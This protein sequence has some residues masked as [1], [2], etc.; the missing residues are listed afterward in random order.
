MWPPRYSNFRVFLSFKILSLYLLNFKPQSFF[1]L[2]LI[3]GCRFVFFYIWSTYLH[4]LFRCICM[5]IYCLYKLPLF[6]KVWI[7]FPFLV[8]SINFFLRWAFIFLFCF[9]I[10]ILN[11]VKYKFSFTVWHMLGPIKKIKSW[12][13][14]TLK[15]NL[16]KRNWFF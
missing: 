6:K 8:F 2:H 12:I 11:L 9:S 3:L 15:S 5:I 13:H 10:F 1:P 14:K 7:C 16:K 4:L